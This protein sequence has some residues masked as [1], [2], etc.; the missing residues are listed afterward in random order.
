MYLLSIC[1]DNAKA[2]GVGELSLIKNK[3]TLDKWTILPSG[4]IGRELLQLIAVA[5]GGTNLF[6]RL[7]F[8]THNLH[9]IISKPLT[10]GFCIASV[11]SYEAHYNPAPIFGSGIQIDKN[12]FLRAMGSTELH[13]LPGDMAKSRARS[14]L[15][16]TSHFIL[17]YGYEPQYHDTTDDFDYNDKFFRVNRFHSLF[18]NSAP[19][20]DPVEFLSRISYRGVA[21]KR[22]APLHVLQRLSYLFKEH[23]GIDT[24]V[25]MDKNCNFLQEWDALEP[26]QKRAALPALDAA[27]HLHYGFQTSKNPLDLPV[28]LL[29]DRPDLLS[30][31]KQFPAWV[32]VMDALLPNAQFLI[33]TDNKMKSCFPA[34]TLSTSLPLPEQQSSLKVI[35][36]VMSKGD[37]LLIDGD[38]VMAN[39]A[40]MKLSQYFKDQGKSVILARQEAYIPGVEAVY[41]SFIFSKPLTETRVDKL[42]KYYGDSL[43]VGGSGVDVVQRLP[44]DIEKIPPDYTL[45]PE[46]GENAIGFL[47]RGCP[48][49][50]PFCVV[51]TKDGQ[52]R[53]VADLDELLQ[54]RLTK[55]ILL[56]DNIL[57]HPQ[58]PYFLEEMVRRNVMVNFTQTLDLRLADQEIARLVKR[59]QCSN[60]KFTRTVY[61]F[62]LNDA[63][64]LDQVAEKY[65]LFGFTGKDNVEFVCM[66]GFNTTL[67]DDV[68][69]FRFLRSLP[70]A[71][72]FVQKYQPIIGGPPTTVTGDRFFDENADDLIDQLIC[73]CFT[74]NMK[75][76]EKYY[77][78]LSKQYAMT[79]GG[80]HEKL[81]ETIFKY[82][83]R[84]QKGSYSSKL[85]ARFT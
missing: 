81:I 19:L 71:Y 76:M 68:E 64:N 59:V 61:H 67:A 36:S 30:G 29:F 6:S 9:R 37:I 35:T 78:W 83:N 8:P 54:G 53:Q 40:L 3:R 1:F 44:E 39:L 75:N 7:D 57:S 45:Y 28:P 14:G 26:W 50:C 69:R 13:F 33:S 56:D 80:I 38:G 82:N 51:P 20:T 49:R 52:I 72:V 10:I 15:S 73:I 12:G 66:Y 85:I 32:R 24:D 25:W 84:Q 62:S 31:A 46:L 2:N 5:C 55:L 34:D 16:Q 27:R 23:L 65:R 42:R 47:T 43:V 77:R 60:I 22:L 11:H 63:H 58:A 70:G 17:G 74:Q 18:L 4:A 21:C 79:F 41:A 48:F